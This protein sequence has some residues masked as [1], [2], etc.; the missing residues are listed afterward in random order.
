M[1]HN[2]KKAVTCLNNLERNFPI[3]VPGT[4]IKCYNEA[5]LLI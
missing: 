1:S 4:S 2:T 5:I 3:L